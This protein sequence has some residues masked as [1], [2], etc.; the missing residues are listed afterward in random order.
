MEIVVAAL[1]R[2]VDDT[3]GSSAEFSIESA[4]F[5]GKFLD[6]LERDQI[7]LVDTRILVIRHFLTV[8]DENVLGVCRTIDGESAGGRLRPGSG[9]RL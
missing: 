4:G 5:D 9:N 3:T 8:D 2:N 7:V 1:G 6:Q